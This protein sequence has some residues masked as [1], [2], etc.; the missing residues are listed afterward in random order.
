MASA[1]RPYFP[2]WLRRAVLTRDD[3]A[4]VYCGA[5]LFAGPVEL[6]VDH[7]AP[8]CLEPGRYYDLDNLVTACGHCN[9]AFGGKP[10]PAA[11]YEDVSALVARRN[12]EGHPTP[13]PRARPLPRAA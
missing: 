3:F 13:P 9:R 6:H 5:S 10:K 12:R 8:F 7:I 1:S 11:V 4:C 2:T